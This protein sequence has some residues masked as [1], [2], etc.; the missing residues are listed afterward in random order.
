MTEERKGQ[1]AQKKEEN[2]KNRNDKT[3]M[4]LIFCS[5]NFKAHHYKKSKIVWKEIFKS[6]IKKINAEVINKIIIL[7]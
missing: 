7:V 4:D 2:R 3:V 6:K 1:K 5:S